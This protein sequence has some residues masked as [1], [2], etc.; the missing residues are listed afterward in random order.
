MRKIRREMSGAIL[1]GVDGSVESQDALKVAQQ[2][3]RRL[4]T[5]LVLAHVVEDTPVDYAAL[6]PMAGGHGAGSLVLAAT[7]QRAEAGEVLLKRMAIDAGVE[8]AERR[9][10]FGYPAERLA[11]LADDEG[12]ELIV[13]GSRGR[14]AFKAAFLGSVSKTL[15]GVARSPILIVPPG[16]T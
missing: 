5:R 13:V 8:H 1:C 15:I 16:V 12:A 2:Y 14:G 7:E 10:A 6:D 9:V 3:A 4:G 11:D